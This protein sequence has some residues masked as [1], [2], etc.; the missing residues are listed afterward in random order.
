MS[1]GSAAGVAALSSMWTTDGAFTT[2]SRVTLASVTTWLDQ[3]SKMLDTALSDEGFLTPVTVVA[4][5]GEFDLLVD[6]IVK[7]LADYSKGSGRFF[8]KKALDSGTSP[9]MTIDK[10]VHEW[11]TRKSIGFEAQ[12]VPR[13][14]DFRGR[15]RAIFEV[16]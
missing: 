2:T 8:T 9:F 6:G 11:V 7:D 12:G 5:L 10:E 4:V 15:H 16:L 1:Y 3:V 14:T 13:R